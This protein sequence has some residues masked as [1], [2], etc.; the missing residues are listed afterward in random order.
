MYRYARV[1]STKQNLDRHIDAL[2]AY[3]VED[4]LIV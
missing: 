1:S 4:R 2:L 3:G